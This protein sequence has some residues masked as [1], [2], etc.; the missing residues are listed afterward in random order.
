MASA[1]PFLLD[2]LLEGINHGFLIALV[3]RVTVGAMYYFGGYAMANPVV[4]GSLGATLGCLLTFA[5]GWLLAA[6]PWIQNRRV[7]KATTFEKVQRWAT[8][9]LLPLSLFWWVPLGSLAVL[10]AGFYRL[11]AWSVA[12]ACAGGSAWYYMDYLK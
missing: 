3:P 9:L 4:W 5:V 2:I 7:R 1:D 10:L 11:P 12:L 6:I 8:R